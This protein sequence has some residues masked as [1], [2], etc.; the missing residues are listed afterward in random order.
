MH[1]NVEFQDKLDAKYEKDIWDILCECDK[2]FVPALSSREDTK[3]Y[4]FS[5]KK[6]SEKPYTYY[7]DVLKTAFVLAVDKDIDKVV[8]FMSFK[9]DY[10]NEKLKSY[11][12]T[13]YITTVCVKSE[14]RNKG[15]CKMFYDF[16]FF[17]LPNEFVASSITTRTWSTNCKHMH[18]LEN[19][20]FD[21]IECIK[22]GRG[23]G[24]DTIYYGRMIPNKV[25][26]CI[27]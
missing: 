25:V 11:M 5:K 26:H 7:E 22:D 23:K 19:L 14:H 18:I 20:K 17:S 13:N 8:G 15:I 6:N 27:K 4:D 24:I 1:L 2:E 9:N 3:A 10:D 16:M 12:P 21:I